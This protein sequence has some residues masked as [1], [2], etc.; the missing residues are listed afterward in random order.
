MY[1][2]KIFMVF[3]FL[4]VT[5]NTGAFLIPLLMILSKF[6]CI[7]I[8]ILLL[9][10]VTLVKFKFLSISGTFQ[11]QWA[12][13]MRHGYGVRSSAPFGLAAHR[14]PSVRKT[15]SLSDSPSPERKP[16]DCRGGFVLQDLNIARDT[17]TWGRTLPDQKGSTFKVEKSISNPRNPRNICSLKG[18][19]PLDIMDPPP[20]CLLK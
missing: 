7:S 8:I 18:N 19:P 11:G 10:H 4:R 6:D 14:R 3:T 2:F 17:G 20:C 5:V 12:K 9:F 15:N 1:L 13:G 16:Q